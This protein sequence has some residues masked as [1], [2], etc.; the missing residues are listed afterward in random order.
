MAGYPA[1]SLRGGIV[2]QAAFPLASTSKKLISR[3]DFCG[4][5]ARHCH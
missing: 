4:Q 1:I 2:R 3:R 5:N